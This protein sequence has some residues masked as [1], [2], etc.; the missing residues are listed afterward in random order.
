[1]YR[2]KP[3]PVTIVVVQCQLVLILSISAACF[4]A[5]RVY[6]S[7]SD[8]NC[9]RWIYVLKAIHI[10]SLRL[11]PA[12]PLGRYVTPMC[13]AAQVIY[14]ILY[15]YTCVSIIVY[16][17]KAAARSLLLREVTSMA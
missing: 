16:V 15:S 7:R 2:G 6:H 14:N 1:M 8:Y 11:S 5:P 10:I 13:E 9:E 17:T 4:N 12:L 3:H